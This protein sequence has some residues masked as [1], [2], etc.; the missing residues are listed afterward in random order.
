MS[1]LEVF[2]MLQESELKF[3]N[4]AKSEQ[5]S[6]SQKQERTRSLKKVTRLIS[7]YH[8]VEVDR[9][10]PEVFGLKFFRVRLQSWFKR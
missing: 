1:Y 7:D 3:Q 8:L 6:Q 4:F 10:A 5:E 9:W 2:G